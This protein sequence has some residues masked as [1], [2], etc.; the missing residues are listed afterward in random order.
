MP[1]VSVSE[2]RFQKS[3]Y[4]SFENRCAAERTMLEP[5]L[6]RQGIHYTFP[7]FTP[8]CN[9]LLLAFLNIFVS[10]EQFLGIGYLVDK[11]NAVEVINFVLNNSCKETRC[12]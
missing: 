5:E 9:S 12:L 3:F 10:P 11:T 2:D 7:W 1:Y 8:P 4:L 6:A